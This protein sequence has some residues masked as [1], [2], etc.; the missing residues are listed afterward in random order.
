MTDSENIKKIADLIKGI[1]FAMLAITTADGHIHSRPMTTQDAVFDGNLWFFTSRNAPFRQDVEASPEV[2]LAYSQPNGNS[3][4][5]VCGT[6]AF[7]E[8]HLKAEELWHPS[9][10]AWFP[11]GVSDPN[12][13]LLKVEVHSAQ[14]WDSPSSGVAHMIALAK[15]AFTGERSDV[16]NSEKVSLQ[17]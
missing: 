16:G 6:A 2:N 12:L 11:D 8:D 15:A 14:Y 17:H 1:K 4:V 10:K 13:I 3:Y 7:V 9:L 5:S